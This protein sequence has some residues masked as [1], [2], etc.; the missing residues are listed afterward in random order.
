M[1]ETLETLV[2]SLGLED[3]LEEGLAAHSSI[4]AWGISWTEEP[5]GLQSMGLQRAAH[6]YVTGCTQSPST[7]NKTLRVTKMNV[8]VDFLPQRASIMNGICAILVLKNSKQDNKSL[9]W[10][11]PF[12]TF[13]VEGF[14]RCFRW[15]DILD[16]HLPSKDA[17][18]QEGG[19]DWQVH[20]AIFKADDEGF[21][22]G[23]VVK[24]PPISVGD[25][26]SIPDPGRLHIAE[27]LPSPC[28]PTTLKP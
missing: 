12:L 20:A 9:G 22:G 13:L 24:N 14:A 27:K 26:G 7:E 8:T 4:L 28:A 21:P 18:G 5:G 16:F 2:W 1:Q 6:S 15:A 11:N 19:W 23:L 17:G 10:P 3:P 25:L